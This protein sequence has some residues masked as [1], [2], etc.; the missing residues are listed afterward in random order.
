[1]TEG[2]VSRR[3]GLVEI[4]EEL[5]QESRRRKRRGRDEDL[6]MQEIF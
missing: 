4:Y 3:S 1:M 2:R 5:D 6:R